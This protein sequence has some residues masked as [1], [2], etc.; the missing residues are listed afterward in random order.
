MG[1]QA[2]AAGPPGGTSTSTSKNGAA[3]ASGPPGDR[4]LLRASF[5]GT[6]IGT[7]AKLCGASTNDVVCLASFASKYS[8]VALFL[9]M[10][11]HLRQRRHQRSRLP[12]LGAAC[13][14]VV[15][16]SHELVRSVA[17]LQ[18]FEPVCGH[19]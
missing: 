15:L 2:F 9:H 17:A 19:R 13:A 11:A 18:M 8:A 3:A 1:L 14:V 10:Q 16:Q 5:V 12:S 7:A 4:E 6:F